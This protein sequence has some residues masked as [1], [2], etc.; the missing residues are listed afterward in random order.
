MEQISV[1]FN[2]NSSI[3]IHEN[4]FESVVC[5]MAAI[6]SW[7]Q[8]VHNITATAFT[9]G[10]QYDDT[11]V[12]VMTCSSGHWSTLSWIVDALDSGIILRM[13]PANERRRYTV[14]SSLIGWEHA[15]N[16]PCWTGRIK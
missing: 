3:F 14:T 15:Q 9:E 7:P 4:E 2:R 12:H 16:D 1:K 10:C 5:E 6:L 11:A 13:R 8:C